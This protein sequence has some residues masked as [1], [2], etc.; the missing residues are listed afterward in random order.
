MVRRFT[1]VIFLCFFLLMRGIMYYPL[2]SLDML[3]AC[4]RLAI[5]LCA[6]SFVATGHREINLI[7][8]CSK[9]TNAS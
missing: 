2:F 4:Y 9:T 1:L 3:Y 7:S 6:S 8:F 5:V